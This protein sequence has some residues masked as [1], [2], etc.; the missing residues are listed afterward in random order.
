MLRLNITYNEIPLFKMFI[1][2]TVD[3]IDMSKFNTDNMRTVLYT[4][5]YIAKN[6]LIS[7]L[8]VGW[9]EETYSIYRPY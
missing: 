7:D 4:Y 5:E 3:Q 1:L 2:D 8:F 6:K 9:T